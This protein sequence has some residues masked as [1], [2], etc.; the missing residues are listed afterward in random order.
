[1]KGKSPCLQ[2]GINWIKLDP[3]GNKLDQNGSNW[4]KLDQ[5]DKTFQIG[6]KWIKF[7]Q[8]E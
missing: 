6:I 2:I 3:I 7:V 1:M 4:N 8:I 5:L